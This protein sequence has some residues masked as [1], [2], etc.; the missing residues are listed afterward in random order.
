MLNLMHTLW[1]SIQFFISNVQMPLKVEAMI[2]LHFLLIKICIRS[3]D[4][5]ESVNLIRNSSFEY[6][7]NIIYTEPDVP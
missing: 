2:P 4:L 3:A 7:Y 5:K 6:L 1:I